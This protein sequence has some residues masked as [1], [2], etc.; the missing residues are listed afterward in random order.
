MALSSDIKETK[1]NLLLAAMKN[2]IFELSAKNFSD[3]YD[4]DALSLV[5]E[6]WH[7]ALK[8]F[9]KSAIES[10]VKR[11]SII[12]SIENLPDLENIIKFSDLMISGDA[13][14]LMHCA[15]VNENRKSLEFPPVNFEDM[16]GHKEKWLKKQELELEEWY[17][18]KREQEEVQRLS[19]EEREAIRSS[20]YRDQWFQL[21][22][23]AIRMQNEQ[24]VENN[25][26]K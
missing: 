14:Y 4:D 3:P 19:Y 1:A 5:I 8:D 16:E 15:L 6:T 11:N 26:Q 18:S 10:K 17:K 7:A 25:H 9:H 2:Y 24:L 12:G 13:L 23:R 22:N 20:F 21:K